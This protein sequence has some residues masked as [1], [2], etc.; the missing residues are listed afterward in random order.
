MF[1]QPIAFCACAG[2]STDGRPEQEN[3]RRGVFVCSCGRQSSTVNGRIELR[4]SAEDGHW[5]KTGQHTISAHQR[6][7][8]EEDGQR[9]IRSMKQRCFARKSVTI[10]RLQYIINNFV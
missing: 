1:L 3:G 2:Q 10:S 6:L 5:T 8:K 4:I 7:Q 9:T